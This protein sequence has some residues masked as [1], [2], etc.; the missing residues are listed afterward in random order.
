MNTITRFIN[1][2]KRAAHLKTIENTIE[3]IVLS[4]AD[5]S[6]YTSFEKV[7]IVKEI[8]KRFILQMKEYQRGYNEN[9]RDYKNR[10]RE[11]DEAIKTLDI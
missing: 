9:A 11:I 5:T 7:Y 3:N 1:K 8:N 6:S 10:G 4:L 2:H